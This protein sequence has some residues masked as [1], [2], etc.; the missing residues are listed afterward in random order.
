MPGWLQVISQV[1]SNWLLGNLVS[2]ISLIE[3][4]IFLCLNY[5]KFCLFI[6][7]CRSLFIYLLNK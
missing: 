4:G 1:T 5:T 7:V 6:M 2:Y 3:M